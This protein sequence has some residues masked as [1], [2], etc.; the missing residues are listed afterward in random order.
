MWRIRASFPAI[1][2]L[3][4]TRTRSG[5]CGRVRWENSQFRL[6][7]SRALTR[8][9]NDKSAPGVFPMTTAVDPQSFLTKPDAF[10]DVSRGNPKPFTL[11]SEDLVKARLTPE[12]W[13]LEILSDGSAD[14]EKPCKLD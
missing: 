14:L 7:V 12:T 10:R 13:R 8:T 1:A 11:K 4:S 2:P 5:R 9:R 6:I 3:H